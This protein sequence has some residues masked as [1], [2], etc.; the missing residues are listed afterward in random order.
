[1]QDAETQVLLHIGAK[2]WEEA[3][4]AT[5]ALEESGV[6]SRSR[7]LR[8]RGML[9][10]YQSETNAAEAM[11]MFYD[12]YHNSGP[13]SPD[14]RAVIVVEATRLGY[15]TNQRW[16]MRR[17]VTLAESLWV[18]HSHD[19]EVKRWRGPTML[20]IGNYLL[21]DGNVED[22]LSAFDQAAVCMSERVDQTCM[23][24]HAHLQRLWCL[25]LLGRIREAELALRAA[26]TCNQ[27]TKNRHEPDM[28]L[29]RSRLA[30]ANGQ[31]GQA[32]LLAI[33]SSEQAAAAGD[34]LTVTEAKY[35]ELLCAVAL[36]SDDKWT[37]A[38]TA[39]E[40]ASK[41][42]LSYMFRLI[43]QALVETRRTTEEVQ[44]WGAL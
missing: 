18:N 4:A 32:I 6:L 29:G 12:A 5:D 23:L 9:L 16:A 39:R 36:G 17:L 26:E 43:K 19:P 37:L 41:Y 13:V 35:Q 20:N 34:G 24:I 10:A 21:R 40:L 28:L 42:H 25:C 22:A 31:P 44:Q 11:Q 33:E 30:S 8:L 27:Q 15:R 14:T 38:N 2:R 1:M 7:V 3:E